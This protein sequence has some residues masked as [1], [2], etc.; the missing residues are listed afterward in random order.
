MIRHLRTLAL[1]GGVS[2]FHA[3]KWLV[4]MTATGVAPDHAIPVQAILERFDE[5]FPTATRC[6]RTGGHAIGTIDVLHNFA[7]HLQ[8]APVAT[9]VHEAEAFF[10][11]I[12]IVATGT[13]GLAERCP[14][15]VLRSPRHR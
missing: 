2:T 10:G 6:A 9:L 4:A 8:F 15:L 5:S 12:R 13:Y 1:S 3:L 7:G 11:D 14:L